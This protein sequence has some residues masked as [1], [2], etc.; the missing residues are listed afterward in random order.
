MIGR[1]LLR[2]LLYALPVAAMLVAYCGWNARWFPA[3]HATNNLAVNE[4]V[5]AFGA[6][7]DKKGVRVLAFGSSMALNN[8]ASAAVVEK[9]GTDRY[10]NLGAWGLDMAQTC[11]MA[12]AFASEYHPSTVI[13]VGNLMDFARSVE[14]SVF[15]RRAVMDLAHTGPEPLAYVRNPALNYY[16]RQMESNKL[17]FTD[18]ANYECLMMDAHGG[19]ALQVPR[20][21]II[22]ER[23]DR[24]VPKAVELDESNYAALDSLARELR[25]MS[26][27]MIYVGAPYRD[28]VRSPE[29]D[30]TIE[31]HTARVQGIMAAHGQHYCD[32]SDRTWPDGLFCDSSHLN[33]EGA[34]EFTRHALARLPGR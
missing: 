13:V 10:F 8:L 31:R 3:P 22:A 16:L 2:C 5:A 19:V 26:I 30:A 15:E 20:D 9:L 28:G 33:G 1:F 32:A 17:R 18:R 23:W 7:P 4:K 12:H 11:E 21:R 6:Q 14:R 24:P 29:A 25:S 34:L 27:P